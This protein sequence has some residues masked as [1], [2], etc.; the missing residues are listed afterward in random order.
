MSSNAISAR[1]EACIHVKLDV[2]GESKEDARERLRRSLQYLIGNG[3]ITGDG[4]TT[5]DDIEVTVVEIV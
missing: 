4:E 3:M 5:V 1:F 2:I